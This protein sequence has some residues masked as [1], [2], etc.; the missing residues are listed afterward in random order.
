M[1]SLY[2]VFMRLRS[3]SMT[4]S[5]LLLAVPLLVVAFFTSVVRAQ[6]PLCDVTCTP[7]PNSNSYPGA[8]VARS[9]TQNARGYSSPIVAKAP[10]RAADAG[11]VSG[12]TV[13]GSQSYNY[14]VPILRLPGR[15]GMDLV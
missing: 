14:T 15:A 13:I 8:V 11:V 3:Y 6:G 9:Q 5:R 12:T 7:D 4:H 2:S 10:L 1:S